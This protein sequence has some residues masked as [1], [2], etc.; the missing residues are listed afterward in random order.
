M[1]FTG[2]LLESLILN[3]RQVRQGLKLALA[4]SQNASENQ[5]LQEKSASIF[6]RVQKDHRKLSILANL[7]HN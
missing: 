1:G 3:F 7:K 2:S 4:N 5:K 6:L